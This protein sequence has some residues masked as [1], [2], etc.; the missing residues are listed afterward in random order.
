MN[1]FEGGV[2]LVWLY[3]IPPSINFFK[4][5]SEIKLVRIKCE[6]DHW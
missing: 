6:V 2:L 5:W 3:I 4:N 1:L